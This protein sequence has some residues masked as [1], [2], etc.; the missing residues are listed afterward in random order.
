VPDELNR[1]LTKTLTG[2]L[3]FGVKMRG[4]LF[5]GEDRYFKENP[6]VTGM[7]A[8]DNSVIINPYSSLSD[9][10]RSAVAR[11]EAARVYMRRNNLTPSFGITPEQAQQFKGTSYESGGAAMLRTLAA[12]IFS[13]DPSAGEITPEQQVYVNQVLGQGGRK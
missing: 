12:R 1:S 13:G 4:K 5:P 9:A 10:E 11:N 6:T 3:P 2:G 7:A 8:E